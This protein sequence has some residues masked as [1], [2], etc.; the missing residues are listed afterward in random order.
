MPQAPMRPHR[1]RGDYEEAGPAHMAEPASPDW[2]T[3]SMHSS[4]MHDP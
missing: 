2:S 1:R 3:P 4:E